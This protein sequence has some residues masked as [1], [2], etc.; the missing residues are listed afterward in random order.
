MYT[1]VMSSLRPDRSL[2]AVCFVDGWSWTTRLLRMDEGRYLVRHHGRRGDGTRILRGMASDEWPR[3][4]FCP[5]CRSSGR[6]VLAARALARSAPPDRTW[7]AAEAFP[8]LLC[9][10]SIAASRRPGLSVSFSGELAR[11]PWRMALPSRC[12]RPPARPGGGSSPYVTEAM[13]CSG[14][15][16][17]PSWARRRT[18]RTARSRH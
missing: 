13:P 18:G 10:R 3:C 4:G 16:R 5:A 9:G 2:R 8:F 6:R 14:P 15:R 11:V 12:G 1:N 7:S 17:D